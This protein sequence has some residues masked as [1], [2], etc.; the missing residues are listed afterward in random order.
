VADE[1]G[2]P[3]AWELNAGTLGDRGSDKAYT[4]KTEEK[5]HLFKS[6]TRKGGAPQ[7]KNKVKIAVWR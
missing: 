1:L 5:T 7:K 6:Q 4:F 3:P 2:G